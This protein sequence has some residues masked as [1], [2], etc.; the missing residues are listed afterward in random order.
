M[1]V[2]MNHAA[3]EADVSRVCR[4]IENLGFEARPI[5]GEQRTS[6]GVVGN[7]GRV[8]STSIEGLPGI[9]RVIHVSSPYKQVSREWKPDNT[10]IELGNGARIGDGS[11]TLFG[12]PCSVESEEQIHTTAKSV[13]AAGAK[14]LRGGAFK[15]RSSPY[16][17]QGLGEEG[18]RIM[19]EAGR[20]NG[21]A[22][23]TEALDPETADLIAEQGDMIQ[24]GARNMQNFSL[25]RHVGR[26]GKPVMLKRG[27][28]ATLE[29]WLLA[30]EY[31]L[32]EGNSEVLLCER[33]IRSFD[34]ATR[35]V[36]D[37]AAIPLAKSLS[38]LPVIA[39]PSHGTGRRDM[40]RP[41]G[42]A[43]VA[44]GADGL[45]VET[46]PDPDAA[47]SDAHQTISLDAFADL[48]HSAMRV[49]RDVGVA[50]VEI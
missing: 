21:L 43:A 20:A 17:F 8:D 26:L 32:S 4:S 38:H 48:A 10:V 15:P 39:D 41:M 24:I 50:A 33:G 40:V 44:A 16:S 12:G 22:V 34:R 9:L 35:N 1:L 5:P 49:S 7:E 18:L 27:M 11:V 30:A 13:A 28:S 19:V 36:L 46:H 47:R 45:M 37:L 14:F 2:V 29:E 6:I 3:T 23:V 42:L 25:L 31:I